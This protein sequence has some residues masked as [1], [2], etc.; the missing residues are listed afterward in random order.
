[1]C[2]TYNLAP[3]SLYHIHN[4]DEVLIDC[5]AVTLPY[6]SLPSN[7]WRLHLGFCFSGTYLDLLSLTDGHKDLTGIFSV[8]AVPR[9]MTVVEAYYYTSCT[10][11]ITA[12]ATAIIGGTD[13]PANPI[14]FAFA[15]PAAPL[16][17]SWEYPDVTLTSLTPLETLT[18]VSA[19][20]VTN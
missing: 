8:I 14:T 9:T 4:D 13:F 10:L 5:S 12:M 6:N 11:T 16:I 3:R 1:M 20:F 17:L 15:S 19:L 18:F 7:C 2:Y